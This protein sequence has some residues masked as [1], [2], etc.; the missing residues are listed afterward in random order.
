MQTK[1]DVGQTVLLPVKITGIHVPDKDTVTY[2]IK[3]DALCI[4]GLVGEQDIVGL[5]EEVYY[6]REARRIDKRSK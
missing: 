4:N 1:Y 2:D 3:I 6:G 5:I